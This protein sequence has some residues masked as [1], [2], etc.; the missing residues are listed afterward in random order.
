MYS[1][2]QQVTVYLVQR[3]P[4]CHHHL[5]N[6]PCPYCPCRMQQTQACAVARCLLARPC[7]QGR[8][9]PTLSRP[10]A[11]VALVQAALSQQRKELEAVTAR[12]LQFI[13]RLLADKDRLAAKCTQMAA[14]GQVG[15]CSGQSFRHRWSL[16]G[17]VGRSSQ[18]CL[19]W[20]QLC[21]VSWQPRA[22]RWRLGPSVMA[23][24][25]CQPRWCSCRMPCFT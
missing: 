15:A 25:A 5:T 3:C 12:H 2:A 11:E 9:S 19:V 22:F 1:A 4:A 8:E 18:E 24:V 6:G 7:L 16:S 17:A 10:D 20:M 21:K 14:D 23:A 13:D